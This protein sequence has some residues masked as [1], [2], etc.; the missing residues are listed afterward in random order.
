MKKFV[1]GRWFPF[2]II[3]IAEVIFLVFLY[4]KNFRITYAPDLENSWGAI[5][6]CATWVSA[7]A[8]IGA[9][10][11]AILIA[12]KQNEIGNRQNKLVE[13]QNEFAEQQ[14]Q[15]VKQQSEFAKQQNELAKQ[16]NELAKQQNKIAEKQAEIAEQQ[17]RIALFEKRVQSYNEISKIIA[18]GCALEKADNIPLKIIFDNTIQYL[19]YNVE[20]DEEYPWITIGSI[21]L[22]QNT[23]VLVKQSAFLFPKISASEI[24]NFCNIF[25]RFFAKF[26]YKTAECPNMLI[27]EFQIKEKLDFIKESKRFKEENFHYILECLR[28]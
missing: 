17:N 23:Q 11:A 15:I 12:L 26:L 9:I 13:Q 4:C 22:T 8:A 19:N 10:V 3:I 28:L 6:A 25:S 14:N 1:K 7:L 24:E 20:E 21:L 2:A 18:F 5:S 16:Q 27:K